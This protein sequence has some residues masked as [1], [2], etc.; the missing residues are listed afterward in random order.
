ML[1]PQTNHILQSR[2]HPK[3]RLKHGSFSLRSPDFQRIKPPFRKQVLSKT[4][5]ASVNENPSRS[6]ISP[7]AYDRSGGVWTQ[8]FSV[9][10]R[11]RMCDCCATWKSVVY[12]TVAA[13]FSFCMWPVRRCRPSGHHA[14]SRSYSA[15][16]APVKSLWAAMG[17]D[18]R[19]IR[20]QF[21]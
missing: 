8:V 16:V 7:H 2:V 12:Q 11:R 9:T 3:Y 10:Q 21:L 19:L 1:L 4:I 14:L 20:C 5:G 15:H 13:C 18:S 17:E 6:R